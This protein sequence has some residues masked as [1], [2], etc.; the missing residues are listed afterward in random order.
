MKGS[1]N[2]EIL[3][4]ESVIK[5]HGYEETPAI[6]IPSENFIEKCQEIAS[7]GLNKNPHIIHESN[8]RKAT[9]EAKRFMKT[10]FRLHN[11]LYKGALANQISYGAALYITNGKTAANISNRSGI[12]I[13]PFWLPISYSSEDLANGALVEN[14]LF[15]EEEEFKK[16]NRISYRQI[17]LPRE[18][19]EL[20]EATYVHE[21]TH[22]QLNDQPGIIKKYYDSEVISIFLELV[23]TL[24]ANGE[25]LLK[26]QDAIRTNELLLDVASLYANNIGKNEIKKSDLLEISKYASS[27]PKAYSL[28]LEY[29]YGT[30]SLRKYILRCIQNMF[31]G[32][33]PLEE[34]LQEFEITYTSST[35][36]PKLIKY[37]SR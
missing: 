24:E 15:L 34:L 10:H 17:I 4:E 36:N 5:M 26:I 20:T 11:V 1:D 28:F 16:R 21:I 18:V 30:P 3:P 19:S 33:L 37:L 7:L 9:K 23:D 35:E 6:I 27:I 32:N 14:A 12:S 2:M 25:R 8:R 22:T 31:D 29:Y 13:S